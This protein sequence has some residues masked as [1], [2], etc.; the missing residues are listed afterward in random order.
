MASEE[1]MV[2]YLENE[3]IPRFTIQENY[4]LKRTLRTTKY[5]DTLDKA[6]LTDVANELKM[7]L[8]DISDTLLKITKGLFD[9]LEHVVENKP[10]PVLEQY[11]LEI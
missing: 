1:Y 2:S 5:F 10:F 6:D 8:D 4:I 9:N 7:S 11:K 3:L